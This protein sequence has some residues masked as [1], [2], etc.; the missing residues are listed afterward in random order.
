MKI[1]HKM[2]LAFGGIALLFGVAGYIS[3]R[4]SEN[5]LQESI[6]ES[7]TSLAAGILDTIDRS[8][9]DRIEEFQACAASLKLQTFIKVSNEEFGKL[10]DLQAYI[11]REDKQWISVPKETVTAFMQ[12]LASSEPAEE[13]KQKLKF[14]EEKYGY[15]VFGEVFVTNKFG[16]N[17]AQTGKTTDY[18]QADEQW[19]QIAREKGLCVTDIEYDESSGNYSTNI[20]IRVDDKDRNFLGVIKTVLNIK[21]VIEILQNAEEASPYKTAQLKL[22]DRD[23]RVIFADIEKHKPFKD[24]L[25]EKIRGNIRGDRGYLLKEGENNEGEELFVYASSKGYRDYRALGWIL[26]IEYSA[27]EVF[28][29]VAKLETVMLIVPAVIVVALFIGFYVSRNISKPV[30]KLRDAAVEVSKGKLDTAIEISS[31]N[32]IGELAGSFNKMTKRLKEMVDNLNR[33]IAERKKT[34]VT[35]RKNE[36]FTR[37][38]L[39]SSSDCINVLDLEGRLLSMSGGG[40][41]LLEIDDIAPYLNASFIDYWK[42]KERE[43]CIEAIEKARKGDTGIFYGFFRTAKGKPKWWE[44]IVTPIKSADGSI[45]RLLAVSRDITERRK[46]EESIKNLNKDLKSTI[47]LLTQSN[48]QL[49]EFAHLA[50]HDLKTPLRGISTLAQWL[51]DDYKGKFDDVGRQQVDLLVERVERMNELINAILQYS[52]ITRKRDK[53]CPVDLNTMVGAVLVE[54]KPPPNIKITINKNLPVVIYRETHL[55]Q[56]FRHLLA[57]AVKFMDKTEGRIAI[58]YT[59]KNDSWEFSV[60]DNG[61]GIAP[62]HFERIFQFFQTLDDNDHSEGGGIGL[63]LVRKIVEL[64]GGQIWLTSELGQGSTFFFTIPKVLSVTNNEKKLLA[65]SS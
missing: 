4:A 40:Q 62:Q 22:F 65:V 20:G 39:E 8:I 28:A 53:E 63:T 23:G 48:R 54:I 55:W 3:V 7:S 61:P 29:P 16:V 21:N 26:A 36:E 34:E 47:T 1:G 42:D 9:Y 56:V 52:T 38:V 17:I 51:V 30:K 15:K 14:Y 12:E 59:V 24:I 41:K 35:L 11:A 58:D 43:S 5:A 2:I 45:D 13:L 32:E 27:K 33:E 50:A 60:S 57:N 19:W 25:D 49:R 6:G 44:V 31:N 10:S 18:Y 46:A 37:R 64:Y